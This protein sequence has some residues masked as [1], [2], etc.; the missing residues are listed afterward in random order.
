VENLGNIARQ[1]TKQQQ[2]DS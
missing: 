2:A 1:F